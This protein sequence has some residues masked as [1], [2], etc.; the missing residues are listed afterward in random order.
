[1]KTI[2][3]AGEILRIELRLP[4]GTVLLSDT[5]DVGGVHAAPDARLHG[6]RPGD[7]HGRVPPGRRCRVR[8]RRSCRRT[9]SCAPTSRSRSTGRSSRSS[10]SGGTRHRS[11][12]TSTASVATSRSSRCSP[13]PWRAVAL[14]LVFRAAQVRILRQTD[15]L[16]RGDDARPDDRHA[17]SRRPGRRAGHGDRRRAPDR[18]D[19]R[20]RAPR[21]R[22]LPEPQRDLR[23][24][25]R[26][27][28][29]HG[30]RGCPARHA[31]GGRPMGALRTRRVPR[32]RHSRP[33]D[34]PRSDGRARPDAARPTSAC[35]SGRP[36]AC[37]SR[38]APGSAPSRS[39]ASR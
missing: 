2:V 21:H 3:A 28:G 39:T 24:P 9:T 12:A 34:R 37:R 33:H 25:G 18:R 1:M 5:G 26:R 38:S 6:G 7:G 20:H 22:Q 10:A 30:G 16:H 4:D 14:Y 8:R 35:G 32:H 13:E 19:A 11:S 27:P 36:S 15:Q 23:P 17:Q 29:A 31:S